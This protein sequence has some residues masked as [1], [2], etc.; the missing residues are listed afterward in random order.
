MARISLPPQQQAVV[1]GTALTPAWRRFVEGIWRKLGGA[2]DVNMTA[3]SMM[4][5]DLTVAATSDT[6]VRI[7][8]VG[9]DGT[10]RKVDLTIS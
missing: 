7:S 6:N 10:T 9:S 4:V 2:L 3:S 1:D 8:F 5:G